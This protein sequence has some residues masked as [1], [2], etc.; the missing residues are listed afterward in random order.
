PFKLIRIKPKTDEIKVSQYC[1]ERGVH[2][3]Q[4]D[5]GLVINLNVSLLDEKEKLERVYE[6]LKGASELIA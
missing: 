3:I 2:F 5:E 1:K 4:S 6:V